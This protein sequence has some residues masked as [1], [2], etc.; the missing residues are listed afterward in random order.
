MKTKRLLS[1]LLSLS[2]CGTMCTAVSAKGID[3]RPT[4][5]PVINVSFSETE[6]TDNPI[7]VTLDITDDEEI[8]K[9]N[10]VRKSV[11]VMYMGYNDDGS[12]PEWSGS[13]PYYIDYEKEIA[14]Y[15]E[16]Y[17]EAIN[18]DEPIETRAE[19]NEKLV[20]NRYKG[21][22]VD[23]Y[24]SNINY[25]DAFE[26][27]TVENNQFTVTVNADYIIYAEDKSGNKTMKVIEINN[28]NV[29]SFDFKVTFTQ[30]YS[31]EYIGYVELENLVENKNS[32]L[33]D[34]VFY[35]QAIDTQPA[36][37]AYSDYQR[38][39]SS[40]IN[41][42][43]FKGYNIEPVDG[44]YYI[45]DFGTYRIYLVSSWGNI[46]STRLQIEPPG[47]KT[48]RILCSSV[49]G[50]KSSKIIVGVEGEDTVM[51]EYA[52]CT[53]ESGSSADEDTFAAAENRQ[54]ITD[55]S[56]T[57]EENGDYIVCAMSADGNASYQVINVSGITDSPSDENY[58]YEITD[59]SILT[60]S[61]GALIVPPQDEN[62]MVE[63]TVNKKEAGD[64]KDYIF[65]AVYDTN[66]MLISLDYVRAN[67]APNYDYSF[68]FNIPAQS[69]KIGSIKAF[70]WDGF[71]S[72][73][74]L[75]CSKTLTFSE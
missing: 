55:N 49:S 62:F 33:T 74:P 39:C 7:T 24:Y 27:V 67:F 57:V 47:E 73:N 66:G 2:L 13:I 37:G 52:K 44:K 46:M 14:E 16:R 60:P 38:Y 59:M 9:V 50:G 40:V 61:G 56:F 42:V 35:R 29:A 68:G 25:P 28:I 23:D 21:M 19:F 22:V 1:L 12:N 8:V 17:I 51:L 11:G 43:K 31:D 65:A 18:N 58:L 4:E 15:E 54:T 20:G 48:S 6:L 3:G 34:I 36:G 69:S 53:E 32:P 10:Y 63:V 64:T 72:M 71:D 26:P 5:A 45:K 41:R 70:I 30:D 75:A